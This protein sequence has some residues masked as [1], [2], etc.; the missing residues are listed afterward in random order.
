MKKNAPFESE[1]RT[2]YIICR[3]VSR[4]VYIILENPCEGQSNNEI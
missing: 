3:L 1:I 4:N 2:I